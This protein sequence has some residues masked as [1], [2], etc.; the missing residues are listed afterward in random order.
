LL[1][2]GVALN[3]GKTRLTNSAPDNRGAG[4][5]GPIIISAAVVRNHAAT[6]LL[7]K[8]RGRGQGDQNEHVFLWIAFSDL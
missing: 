4:V 5:E 7:V 2:A 8:G 1:S 6:A 3:P